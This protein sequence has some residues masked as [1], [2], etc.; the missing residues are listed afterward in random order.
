MDVAGDDV[1]AVAQKPRLV[2]CEEGIERG[3]R[4]KGARVEATRKRRG[5]PRHRQM[6]ATNFLPTMPSTGRAVQASPMTQM[7]L[8]LRLPIEASWRFR[9]S[10]RNRDVRSRSPL[11]PPRARSVPA[12]AAFAG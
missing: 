6:V 8:S 1:P 3:S 7:A 12:R 5:R 2:P 4:R 9:G 10:D 11:A